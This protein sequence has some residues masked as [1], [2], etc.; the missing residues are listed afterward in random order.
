M[1]DYLAR[2]QKQSRLKADAEL[3]QRWEW[4]ARNYGDA[5][6]KIELANAK[7]TATS[8]QKARTQFSNVKP[9]HDL[10]ISAAASALRSLAADLAALATWAK[11]YGAFCEAERKREDAAELK[12][13]A[14]ERW[15]SDESAVK[16]EY[17]FI[18]ELVSDEGQL[19][20]GAWCH[21]KGKYLG[22]ETTEI[23]GPVSR[24]ESEATVR[25]SVART[26]QRSRAESKLP[27]SWRGMRGNTVICSWSDYE[28]Y[29]EDRKEASNAALRIVEGIATGQPTLRC[30]R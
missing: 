27:N 23:H 12:A 11:T 20:F 6:I 28:H 9:E 10:A 8:M 5:K 19:A 14:Q 24:I 2:F 13:I 15:G 18:R 22:C 4:S 3:I 25:A 1:S 17:E 30:G 29:L 21:S 7:R 26:V 16:F